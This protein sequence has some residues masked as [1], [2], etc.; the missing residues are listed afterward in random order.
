MKYT[1][2]KIGVFAA[3]Y[4][5][6]NTAYS[7]ELSSKDSIENLLERS[8][9]FSSQ[10]IHTLKKN[11]HWVPMIGFSN[12]Q[13]L[14]THHYGLRFIKNDYHIPTELDQIRAI[15]S[16]LSYLGKFSDPLTRSEIVTQLE[17]TSHPF[18]IFEIAGC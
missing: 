8:Y 17:K 7:Q 15:R 2:L 12:Y 14:N 9:F 16:H 5:G 1:M 6:G 3:C 13:A 18:F 11:M 4:I 10:E